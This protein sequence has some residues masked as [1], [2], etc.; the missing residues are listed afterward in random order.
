MRKIMVAVLLPA[1][2]LL[3]PVPAYAYFD[4]LLHLAIPLGAHALGGKQKKRL[5]WCP[6]EPDTVVYR[7]K[8]NPKV[9]LME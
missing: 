5:H 7:T 2:L 8:K 4:A 9:G 6:F 3:T 1:L